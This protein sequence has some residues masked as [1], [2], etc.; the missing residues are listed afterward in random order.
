VHLQLR[1]E[2]HPATQRAR[3][4]ATR[5]HD[6]VRTRLV[7]LGVRRPRELA[8]ALLELFLG[9]IV[10]KQLDAGG[11]AARSAR[12]RANQLLESAEP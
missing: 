12:R 4:Y 2:E 10:V 7:A 3:E 8:T 6:F 5:I 11:H 9:A 1:D